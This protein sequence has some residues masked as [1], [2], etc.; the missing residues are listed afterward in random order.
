MGRGIEISTVLSLIH[1]H[2][3]QTGNVKAQVWLGER[4]NAAS[5]VCSHG[6]LC[7]GLPDLLQEERG[8]HFGLVFALLALVQSEILE[9]PV[10]NPPLFPLVSWLPW[11]QDGIAVVT[12]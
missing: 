4:G 1:K 6:F 2:L 8:A 9:Q 3:Q 12:G 11:L 10:S 7:V 5:C